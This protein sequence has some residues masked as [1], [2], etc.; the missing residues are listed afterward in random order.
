MRVA[1]RAAP[2]CALLLLLAA[3]A[4]APVAHVAAQ[5]PAGV[6]TSPLGLAGV[7]RMRPC[8]GRDG[9]AL[10]AVSSARFQLSGFFPSHFLF[11]GAPAA[12]LC[13]QVS[14]LR[15]RA[16][17]PSPGA[18]LPWTPNTPPVPAAGAAAAPNT[19]PALAMPYTGPPLSPLPPPPPASP[20]PPPTNPPI[21][22]PPA[23]A[24]APT[25]AALAPA[26][27]SLAGQA[28]GRGAQAAAPSTLAP[29]LRL[30]GAPEP[31]AGTGAPGGGSG[32]VA[33]APPSGP[34]LRAASADA[35]AGGPPAR[36]L[37]APSPAASASAGAGSLPHAAA[38]GCS[39]VSFSPGAATK[40]HLGALLGSAVAACA[41][42]V[43]AGL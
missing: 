9:S 4:A 17:A 1:C 5:T 20:P 11:G 24:R 36:A 25:P 35:E 3:L 30:L 16:P 21:A 34:L 15:T 6:R 8:S 19:F 37:A 7:Q 42:P 38:R 14:T 13:M 28:P 33:R 18:S 32:G 39:G 2:Q 23:Y 10:G 27:A 26:P 29:L 40:T 41:N 22:S 31:A 12:F 43:F